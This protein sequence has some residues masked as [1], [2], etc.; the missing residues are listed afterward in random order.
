MASRRARWIAAAVLLVSLGTG[1]FVETR[2]R[3]CRTDCWWDHGRRICEKRC[4]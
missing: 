1:C 4:R 3:P 2:H